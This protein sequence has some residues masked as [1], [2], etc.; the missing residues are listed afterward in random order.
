MSVDDNGVWVQLADKVHHLFGAATNWTGGA[1]Y[2]TNGT[3]FADVTGDGFMDAIA[4]NRNIISGYPAI[5]VR[6]STGSS[7]GAS[8]LS[9]RS[10]TSPAP[11]P[12]YGR[13]V[14]PTRLLTSAVEDYGLDPRRRVASIFTR[15]PRGPP[16]PSMGTSARPTRRSTTARPIPTRW[17]SSSSTMTGST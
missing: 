2:G 11:L 14:P 12:N 9:P 8:Q 7:F 5:S 17:T 10:D 4:V 1:F 6:P 3:F 15:I 16:Q 13:R